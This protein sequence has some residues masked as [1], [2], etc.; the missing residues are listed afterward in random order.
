MRK[1]YFYYANICRFS[2]KPYKHLKG[3]ENTLGTHETRKETQHTA[4]TKKSNGQNANGTFKPIETHR[5]K[6]NLIY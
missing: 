6:H 4:V 1:I 2:I 3:K 5:E